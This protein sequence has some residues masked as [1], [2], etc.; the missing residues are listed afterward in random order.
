MIPKTIH[1]CWFSDEEYPD[2]IRQCISSWE[3]HLEGFRI[4]HWGMKDICHL[5]KYPFVSEAINNQKWAFAADY[6]RL[7]ALYTEGGIYLDSDVEI[8]RDF[9]GFCNDSLFFGTEVIEQDVN[10][11]VAVFGSEQGNPILKTIMKYYETHHFSNSLGEL[12]LT[13]APTIIERHLRRYGYKKKDKEQFLDNGIHIYPS[14]IFTNI[15]YP[16]ENVYSLHRITHS[17][18]EGGRSY[19]ICKYLHIMPCYYLWKKIR[20]RLLK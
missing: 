9:S 14:N 5:M 18:N 17:W 20:R 19:N 12:D 15:C 4:K 10:P 8:Y 1:Y 3:R 6:V 11:D 16:Q 2:K 13:P 7:Y